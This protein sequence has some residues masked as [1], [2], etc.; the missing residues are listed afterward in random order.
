LI[1]NQYEHQDV[2]KLGKAL[3]LGL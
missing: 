1:T 2:H 3:G